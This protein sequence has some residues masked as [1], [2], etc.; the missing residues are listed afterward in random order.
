M[1]R[2]GTGEEPSLFRTL[3][4]QPLAD[5]LRPKRL[6]EV[7]GQDHLLGPPGVLIGGKPRQLVDVG[8]RHE[9]G[10]QVPPTASPFM[11]NRK[12]RREQRS[13]RMGPGVGP[14]ETVELERVSER[15]AT[16]EQ[17]IGLAV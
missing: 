6:E 1:V 7:V 11:R 10:D 2:K 4:P 9:R 14:G 8:A 5:R 15:T 3:A 13:P 12:R 16:L 17:A